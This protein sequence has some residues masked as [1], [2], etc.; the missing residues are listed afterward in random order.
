MKYCLVKGRQ[1]LWSHFRP[2]AL[3]GTCQGQSQYFGEHIRLQQHQLC[4]QAHCHALKEGFSLL[5][6]TPTITGHCI[7]LCALAFIWHLPRK[8][9]KLWSGKHYSLCL[10]SQ[11][12]HI[13]GKKCKYKSLCFYDMDLSIALCHKKLCLIVLGRTSLSSKWLHESILRGR[14]K[15][16][17]V[18]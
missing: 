7:Y 12:A 16:F 10:V 2:L 9:L 1:R 17:A 4:V 14:A 18:F 5:R 3:Q 13:F 6:A 8:Y 11:V 15:N